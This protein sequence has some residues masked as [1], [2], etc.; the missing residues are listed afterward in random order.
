M[1]ARGSRSLASDPRFE[2]KFPCH[3][4]GL[5]S[6]EGDDGKP[7]PDADRL[8]QREPD[9]AHVEIVFLNLPRLDVPQPG[10]EL[11]ARD[12]HLSAADRK[13]VRVFTPIPLI[14]IIVVQRS[15]AKLPFARAIQ[16]K[17]RVAIAWLS[18]LRSRPKS[19][20]SSPLDSTQG[21]SVSNHQ[22]RTGGPF[23]SRRSTPAIS[24]TTWYQV[25]PTRK[26]KPEPFGR[27]YG[28]G[29]PNPVRSLTWNRNRSNRRSA[30]AVAGRV[31]VFTTQVWAVRFPTRASTC[32]TPSPSG[33]GVGHAGKHR[34]DL[35]SFGAWP[36]C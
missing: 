8:L 21:P 6:L 12:A 9:S 34:F 2:P 31:I 26:S 7:R 3:P 10:L 1:F 23:F 17:S 16:S 25:V 11:L 22:C 30:V 24:A 13:G 35:V 29:T 18:S 33:V 15:S 4:I 14:I 27:G 5:L 19:T 36:G 20:T 28:L 32:I